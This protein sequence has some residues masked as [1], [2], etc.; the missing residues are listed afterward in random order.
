MVMTSACLLSWA[1]LPT[2]DLS[3]CVQLPQET[4]R[5]R[6]VPLKHHLAKAAAVTT[7]KL[8]IG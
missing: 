8:Q 3:Q 1:A 2:G 7:M 4:C 6:N 5:H